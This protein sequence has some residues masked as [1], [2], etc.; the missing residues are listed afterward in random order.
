MGFRTYYPT[1]LAL[2]FTS[3][4]VDRTLAGNDGLTS[5]TPSRV[6]LRPKTF[7]SPVKVRG[8]TWLNWNVLAGDEVRIGMYADGREALGLVFD[9]GP[10]DVETAG[11]NQDTFLTLPEPVQLYRGRYWQAC[12][13]D[14]VSTIIIGYGRLAGVGIGKEFSGKFFDS[15]DGFAGGL[16]NAISVADLLDAEAEGLD[17]KMQA[18]NIGMWYG[19]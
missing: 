2:A 13:I 3:Q 15:P 12:M 1:P 9:S 19:L 16:P 6:Y 8:V 11:T 7:Q 17:S 18:S 14:S 5:T 4:E 10:M